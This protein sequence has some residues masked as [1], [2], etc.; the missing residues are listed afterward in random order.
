MVLK[1]VNLHHFVLEIFNSTA[2]GQHVPFF[3]VAK[4]PSEFPL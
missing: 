3:L 2:P 4:I 1:Q